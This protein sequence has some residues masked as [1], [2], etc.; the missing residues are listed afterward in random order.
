MAVLSTPL[1][2]NGIL[3]RL[4]GKPIFGYCLC[5][6]KPIPISD[7]SSTFDKSTENLSNI[8]PSENEANLMDKIP[9][10]HPTQEQADNSKN[11]EEPTINLNNSKSEEPTVSYHIRRYFKVLTNILAVTFLVVSVNS[12]MM[13]SFLSEYIVTE[14]L[15]LDLTEV[16]GSLVLAISGIGGLVFSL[17]FGVLL[18]LTCFKEHRADIVNL[19]VFAGR[20]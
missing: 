4:L 12:T 2:L 10:P 17:L 19:N 15:L 9:N 18:D 7:N 1:L 14:D 16:Q 5:N 13:T 3:Y 6:K 11:F 8:N 20:I